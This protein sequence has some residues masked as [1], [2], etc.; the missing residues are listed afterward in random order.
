MRRI[1]NLKLKI[2]NWVISFVLV[3]SSFFKRKEK[4]NDI[5]KMECSTSTQKMGI[6]FTDK[7]RDIFRGRW[8][9]KV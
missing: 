1:E 9:K 5:K 6:S 3:I 4:P 2:E 7:I 8:I